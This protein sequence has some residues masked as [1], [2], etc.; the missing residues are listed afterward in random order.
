KYD[1][2]V[3]VSGAIPAVA[4]AAGGRGGRGGGPGGADPQSIPAEYRSQLGRVTADRTI[5]QIR[6]FIENGGTVVALSDSAMNLAGQLK[7]PIENHL[8]ENGSPV[9][10]SKYFVPGSVLTAKVDVTDPLAWGMN[11]RTD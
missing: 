2:L 3:F 11:E 8:M 6:T 1:V 5:P 10:P 4:S 9:P 7:L